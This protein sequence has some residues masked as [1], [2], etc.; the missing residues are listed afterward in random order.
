LPH[1]PHV[2]DSSGRVYH[3]IGQRVS[4]PGWYRSGG[5]LARASCESSRALLFGGD[6]RFEQ[7]AQARMLV[8]EGGTRC[9]A[10]APVGRNP[11]DR[12]DLVRDGNRLRGEESRRTGCICLISQR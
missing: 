3:P 4:A 12:R 9:E 5:S 11:R 7:D 8:G 1:V 10:G 2:R 6:T